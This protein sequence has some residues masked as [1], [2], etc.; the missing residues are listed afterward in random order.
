MIETGR[1]CY[2]LAGRDSGKVVVVVD[3]VDNNFVL[4]DGQV[5]R[6][7]CNI[8]HLEPTETL[9]KIKKNATHQEI[10][11]ELKKLNIDVKESKSKEKKEKQ[12]RA[13]KAK[14]KEEKKQKKSKNKK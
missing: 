10:V 11:S 13:R 3:K 5:K 8:Q 1:L 6:K 7:R 4:I 2:K 9:L 14:Q 12:K